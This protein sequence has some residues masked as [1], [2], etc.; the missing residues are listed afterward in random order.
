MALGSPL[1][2]SLVAMLKSIILTETPLKWIT[3][4]IT[5]NMQILLRTETHIE[6][7]LMQTQIT[8]ER[9]KPTSE[10]FI[11]CTDCRHF[12][13]IYIRIMKQVEMN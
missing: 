12:Y 8:R 5:W 11:Y 7:H 6:I 1:S 13:F 9:A 2:K 4:E 10:M 3:M